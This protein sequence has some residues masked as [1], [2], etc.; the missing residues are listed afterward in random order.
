[1]TLIVSDTDMFDKKQKAIEKKQDPGALSGALNFLGYATKESQE[2]FGNIFKS[3]SGFD[4]EEDFNDL[5][6]EYLNFFLYGKASQKNDL[7]ILCAKESTHYEEFYYFFRKNE[8]VY[9]QVTQKPIEIY[10]KYC[11]SPPEY[12]S[13]DSRD[14]VSLMDSGGGTGVLV[15]TAELYEVGKGRTKQVLEYTLS[16]HNYTQEKIGEKYSAGPISYLV[17]GFTKTIQMPITFSFNAPERKDESARTIPEF[18]LLK[19]TYLLNY[20]WSL[21]NQAFVFNPASSNVPFT[22]KNEEDLFSLTYE[23]FFHRYYAEL[24][25][26]AQNG[27]SGQKNW[28]VAFLKDDELV[29]LEG[30]EEMKNLK[31]LL[32]KK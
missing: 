17:K 4:K 20:D 8:G 3:D 9:K 24:K 25:I 30:S 10:S 21:L 12:Y 6:V 32:T 16:G 23:N 7:L 5:T 2:K 15:N 18:E 27:N 29:P 19:Q 26:L 22:I 28:L 1:M 14:Y 13:F 11:D 31:T